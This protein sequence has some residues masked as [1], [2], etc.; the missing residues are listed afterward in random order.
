M[1]RQFSFRSTPTVKMRRSSFPLD[2]GVKTTMNVGELIPVDC[3]EVYPGDTFK[4]RE[5]HVAR[6]ST[7]YLRP[8]MDNVFMDIYYF[9]VPS[10]LVFDDAERVFGNP[11]PSAYVDND[12]AEFPSTPTTMTV[13]AKSVGRYLGLPI[14]KVPAGISLCKFRGFAL[15]YNEWFRNENVTD[16]VY[17]HTGN[18]MISEVFN[19]NPWS[20]TNY[21]GRCPYVGKKKDYFTSA[22]P[23]PQKGAQVTLGLSGDAIVRTSDGVLVPKSPNPLIMAT[24]DGVPISGMRNMA[25][26]NSPA[27][28]LANASVYLGAA[29]S[30][31]PG[32][33]GG[34]HPA[35]LYADLSEVNATNVNDMRFAFAL[36][37]MLEA[38][39][40]YGTRYR[41]YILGHFG[42]SNGDARM[43]IPEFLGGKRT[44]LNTMQVAQTSQNSEGNPLASLGAYSQSSGRSRYTKSFTEHGFVYTL[45]CIR[46]LHTYQQGID[47]SWFRLKR[48][49]F[50]DPKFANLGEQP[51]Y[52]AE[53]FVPQNITSNS[54]VK[55]LG[56][57]GY[58]EAWA[59]L[60]Y[61]PSRISGQLSTGA[62]NTLDVYHFGDYY[63]Q[64]P[65]LTN[66]FILESPKFFD[67]TL[68]V[69]SDKQDN[70]VVDFWFNMN[71]VR[72]MP[73]Y[74]IPGLID[75]H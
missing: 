13:S 7:S 44:P 30:D 48:E 15:I 39:A 65:T 50:Y 66:D 16:E 20:T 12:L 37:K 21:T 75:H 59:D 49:D 61:L 29:S 63:S 14:G 38:D 62:E 43:Q 36:Q 32:V 8:V 46:Q 9:F 10:R 23:S 6:L 24:P 28:P 71:A 45:A 58:N 17:V 22:L 72:V 55:S 74:S 57:F 26:W 31:S 53:L 18:Y 52:N 69:A 5:A 4:C 34:L 60:R 73:L 33:N 56:V 3:V 35:N 47:K 19:D 70:F 41:E 25:V 1:S 51:I 27:S 64:T 68:A 54:D 67:R 40:R 2:H 11:K 42:V